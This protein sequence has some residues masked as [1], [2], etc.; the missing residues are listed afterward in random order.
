LRWSGFLN[1]VPVQ[2][3][4]PIGAQLVRA[5]VVEHDHCSPPGAIAE[6]LGDCGYSVA[7]FLVVPPDR[8]AT[9]AVD[10]A[11]PDF[12]AYDVVVPMGAPWSVDDTARIGPWVT[13][14][15]AELRRAYDAGVAV[16]GIC[17]G[18]QALAVA[19]GGTVERSPAPEIGWQA[20]TPLRQVGEPGAVEAGPW[21]QFHYD[22]FT[23]PPG[24]RLVA[25]GE[26]CPEAYV[27]GRSLGV[28]FHPEITGAM[29]QGWYDNGGLGAVE[30]AGV[31]ATALLAETY[32]QEAAAR[33]RAHA[34]V[35]SFL[36]L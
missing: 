15:L 18:A 4:L 14:E 5:L 3:I 6:R 33:L 10:V 35:D 24:A 29:L 25:D 30:A 32:A 13:P 28:Q 19:L 26:H 20:V 22:R 7:E 36:A 34:L 16:L 1:N 9:P 27:V 23:V 21:F 11:L 12:T 8:F 17:F 31:D 2:T